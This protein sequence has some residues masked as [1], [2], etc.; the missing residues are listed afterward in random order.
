MTLEYLAGGS[1]QK[2][3]SKFTG[4]VTTQT[5]RSLAGLKDNKGGAAG[6]AATHTTTAATGSAAAASSLHASHGRDGSSGDG[7]KL[8]VDSAGSG[9]AA[10]ADKKDAKA[11]G[12]GFLTF[13]GPLV[14]ALSPAKRSGSFKFRDDVNE[15]VYQELKSLKNLTQDEVVKLMK[16]IKLGK[17]ASQF[18]DNHIDGRVL[19]NVDTIED[20]E[21]LNIRLPTNLANKFLRDL[22]TFKKNGVLQDDIM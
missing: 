8:S 11:G 7:P 12:G 20:L 9:G 14:A 2:T 17:Y 15:S 22:D 16:K 10:E 6:A 5:R 19:S 4:E 21:V 18:S 3:N 13:L 1:F